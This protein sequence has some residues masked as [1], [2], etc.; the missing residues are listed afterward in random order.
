MRWPSA[1]NNVAACNPPVLRNSGCA[2]LALAP[3]EVSSSTLT[4][5]V[6]STGPESSMASMAWSDALPQTPQLEVA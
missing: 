4:R 3:S 6:E 2:A 1:S 5:S